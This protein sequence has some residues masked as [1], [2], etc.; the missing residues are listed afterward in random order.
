MAY[1]QYGETDWDEKSG[2]KSEFLKLKQGEDDEN[3][4]RVV[5][6]P[7]KFGTHH[8]KFPDDPNKKNGG[9]RRVHCAGEKDGCVL[10]GIAKA[11][12]KD[13]EFDVPDWA[14]GLIVQKYKPRWYMGVIARGVKPLIVRTFEVGSLI[15]N[16]LKELNNNKKWGDPRNYDITIKVNPDAASA[17]E[18]YSVDG[19][20]D[21]RGP[22]SQEDLK[23]VSEFNVEALAERCKPVTNDD[24]Q[25]LI[26]NYRERIV[27]S[28]EETG[29][30]KNGKAA[31][32]P[33]KAEK[34]EAAAPAEDDGDAEQ[35][36]PEGNDF[37]FK[38]TTES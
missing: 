29:K 27:K 26:E 6:K 38:S 17:M 28:K 7:H 21:A 3:Q 14:E 12:E 2:T 31:P 33:K 37:G 8:V 24:V 9:G 11:Q 19:D 23:L 32:A 20:P 15:R 25:K 30:K 13:L 1:V 5:T 35:A 22:M 10:C 18:Y 16:R 34:A 36:A 4:L